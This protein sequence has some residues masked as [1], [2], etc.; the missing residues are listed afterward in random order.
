MAGL[1]G[2]DGE[3]GTNL[4]PPGE[5]PPIAGSEAFL[6]S[7]GGNERSVPA[8]HILRQKPSRGAERSW[9]M[10]G[11][12]PARNM[13]NASD[14]DI[15]DDW[16][17]EEG[18]RKNVKWI[19]ELGY[20]T[21]GSPVVAGGKVF[22]VTNNARP[23]DP[24]VQGHKA[25]LMAFRERDGEFLWQIAHDVPAHWPRGFSG[26]LSST[27]AVAE[28]NLY[29]DTSAGEVVCAD[30]DHGK[31]LWRYDMVKKLGVHMYRDWCSQRLAPPWSSPLVVGD[32]VFAATGNGVDNDGNLVSP[33]APS[34]I[35]L[36]K[37]TGKLVWQ[38]NL[39]SENTI[40]G[41]WCSPAFADHGVRP[42]VIFA[43]GDGVIYSFGPETG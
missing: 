8:L 28:G 25:V 21:I 3:A 36:D 20:R 40:E 37:R 18:K 17:V 5:R 38:S 35:A 26:G 9:P 14:Q 23:R 2:C 13:V 32:H 4:P 22:V 43:G 12:S 42:Q 39:P 15:P 19:A 31:I 24:K 16:C 27:P 10:F 33:K 11:G 7:K 6:G 41:Q 1:I 34:L 29:Y 30:A